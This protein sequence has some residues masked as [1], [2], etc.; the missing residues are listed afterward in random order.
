V[1]LLLSLGVDPNIADKQGE[2]PRDEAEWWAVKSPTQGGRAG[3]LAVLQLLK[4]SGAT[5][6][7]VYLRRRP[8]LESWARTRHIKVPWARASREVSPSC[9]DARGRSS[10]RVGLSREEREDIVRL[11]E[12]LQQLQRDI[13]SLDDAQS[14]QTLLWNQLWWS[15][16]SVD[17]FV[18]RCH[19]CQQDAERALLDPIRSLKHTWCDH[20]LWPRALAHVRR[21]LR[22]H[23]K[24][25]SSITTLPIQEILYTQNC[26]SSAF[27]HGA[28]RGL[29]V[30][31]LAEDL[32]AGRVSTTDS[33][34]TLDVIE[35]H[36]RCWSLNNRHLKADRLYL[37]QLHGEH[38]WLVTSEVAQ[39]ASVRI[40][41]L[42]P[43]L[44]LHGKS[45]LHK[46]NEALSTRDCGRSLSLRSAA[47]S[48][49]P[50]RERRHVRF[51]DDS[52]DNLRGD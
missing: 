5:C 52:W 35:Y 32:L 24:G 37:E 44:K 43:D 22:C 8:Q 10:R 30:S 33:D 39:A 9:M 13:D 23:L 41:P 31:G 15:I 20:S 17:S 45:V 16:E 4:A 14:S 36:G 18:H 1:K 6:S 38:S 51:V 2:R 7:A 21:V 26:A 42:M 34:M 50:S 19:E 3:C 28:H 49:S 48:R 40:W 25:P 47:S 29:S 12:K 27:R 11:D 46:F